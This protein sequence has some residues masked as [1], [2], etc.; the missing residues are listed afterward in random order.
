MDSPCFLTSCPAR[1]IMR[2]AVWMRLQ[3]GSEAQLRREAAV[4]CD[5][6]ECSGAGDC[7]F[8]LHFCVVCPDHRVHGV[9]IMLSYFIQYQVKPSQNARINVATSFLS[10]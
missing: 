7:D 2:S 9:C 1:R 10:K 4:A 6:S 3:S 5:L 8:R